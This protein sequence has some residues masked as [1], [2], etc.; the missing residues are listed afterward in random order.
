M[1]ACNTSCGAPCAITL[2]S[3][4]RITPS[5][6]CAAGLKSCTDHQRNQIVFVRVLHHAL[7]K[8]ELM[9]HIQ[10]A[11]RFVQHQDFRTAQHDLGKHDELPLSVGKPHDVAVRQM[12]DASSAMILAASC[13]S[14]SP[15][16]MCSARPCGRATRL[17]ARSAGGFGGGVL[18]HITYAFAPA[19]QV[20]FAQH[21]VAVAD[22]TFVLLRRK[23]S[24]SARIFPCRWGRA[25]DLPVPASN[26]YCRRLHNRRAGCVRFQVSTFPDGLSFSLVQSRRR[27]GT[28]TN[29]VTI[30]T[31]NSA[32][33]IIT[34]DNTL[35][36]DKTPPLPASR[37]AGKT[38][39]FAKESAPHAAQP[40]R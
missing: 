22:G 30:P 26:R 39:V 16:C 6:N 36:T 19:L 23:S 17:P 10:R 33:G 40:N 27:N 8:I 38:L 2:P 24:S 3:P 35:A 12:A 13:S 11:D 7:K 9:V 28:P 34:L 20:D 14:S 37:R 21:F 31:G 32:P 1:S 29:D 18:R 5:E 15:T 25:R 4:S